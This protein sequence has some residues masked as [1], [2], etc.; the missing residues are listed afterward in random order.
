MDNLVLRKKLNTYKSSSGILRRVGDEVVI[1]VLRTWENWPGRA[2]EL[3]RE[4]GLSKMQLVTMIQKAKRLIKNGVVTESDFKE[5]KTD[6]FIPSAEA[7]NCSGLI[8]M[9]W[10]E[11]KQIRFSQVDQLVDFL[12]KV[13]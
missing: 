4:L 11:K 8:S 10:D 12:K 2:V 9:N 3:Y 1:E 5:L 13:A 6:S 7:S